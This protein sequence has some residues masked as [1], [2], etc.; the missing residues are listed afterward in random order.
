MTC[1]PTT[2]PEV[3]LI[4]PDVFPDARGAFFESFNQAKMQALGIQDSFIQDNVSINTKGVLRGLHFQTGDFAQS[5]LV[6]VICGEVFDVA[7]DCRKDSPTYGKWVSAI[8]SEE[9]HQML[10]IPKGFAHGFYALK[11]TRFLY[12]VGGSYYNKEASSG[13][14]WN[15]PQLSINWPLVDAAP[16]VLSPQD[17]GLPPFGV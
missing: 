9:N 2:I 16:P 5:K 14:L 12:K 8:L 10:Y 6:T 13:V 1:I 4:T 3:L 7:V 15:D 17:Q 11:D